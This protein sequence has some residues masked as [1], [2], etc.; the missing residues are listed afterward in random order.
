VSAVIP[1]LN[2]PEARSFLLKYSRTD[3]L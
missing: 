2:N 1:L 3:Q